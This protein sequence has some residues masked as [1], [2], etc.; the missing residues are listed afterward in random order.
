[1]EVAVKDFSAVNLHLDLA[2]D[3]TVLIRVKSAE[4]RSSIS[5]RLASYD[6]CR[7]ERTEFRALPEYKED[8]TINVLSAY[9]EVYSKK[10]K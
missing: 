7:L 10:A 6:G 2:E 1:M 8:R 9:H 4:P 3:E 5:V